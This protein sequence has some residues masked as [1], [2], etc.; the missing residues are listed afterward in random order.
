MRGVFAGLLMISI[1]EAQTAAPT[2]QNLARQADVARDAKQLDKAISL[3]Q[4]A[5]KLKPDWD[6]G[7]WSL[8]S[9]TYDLDRYAECDLAFRRLANL[10]AESAPAWTMAG[11]CEYKLRRYDAVL[12]SLSQAERLKF[13]EPA[14]LAQAARLHLA[15]VLSKTGSFE[16]AIAVL[17]EL[18]RADRKTPEIIAAAG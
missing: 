17:T 4:Q 14:P 7:L 10:K 8:G 2:F 6:E 12:G 5:L 3:Y 9:I 13:Q 1:A 15:L 18:T 11:L 16:K